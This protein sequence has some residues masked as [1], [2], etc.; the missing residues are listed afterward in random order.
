MKLTQADRNEAPAVTQPFV[1]VTSTCSTSRR[2]AMVAMLMAPVALQMG[3]VRAA[4]TE[5]EQ[6]L[7]RFLADTRS[8]R[9]EFTQT[10][11]RP[12]G[13]VL[14]TLKGRF[15]FIR[16]GRFR[17]E[18]LEPYRQLLLADGETLYFFDEDLNQVTERKLDQALS[19]TPAAILFGAESIDRDFTIKPLGSRDGQQWLE[20]VPRVREAGVERIAMGFAGGLPQAMEVVDAFERLSRFSLR[21]IERNPPLND[22]LFRFTAPAG[23]DIVRQ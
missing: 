12:G 20:A 1:F 16:P 22:A 11:V 10:L 21:G 3:T 13:R 8:A 18:V 5:A 23:A 17:W 19:A 9:G 15:A 4:D 2:Q 6:Q 7:R 14:E